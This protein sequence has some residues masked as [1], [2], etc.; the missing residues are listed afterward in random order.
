MSALF[1]LIAFVAFV[2]IFVGL[3]KPSLFNRLSKKPMTRLRALG[4]FGGTF[5]VALILAAA[6]AP[7]V[8]PNENQVA[9]DMG[10]ETET[11]SDDDGSSDTAT[12][13]S[14]ATSAS[15]SEATTNN[16]GQT[17]EEDE[18]AEP[19][20]EP[21]QKTAASSFGNGTFVV[22]TDIQP[23]TYRTR[24]SSYG[25][26]YARLSGF[27]GSFSEIIANANTNAPAVIT[28]S[29]SDKGFESTR[30]G[31]WTQDLSA[32]T[33][34]QTS[35]GDGMYIVGTDIEPGTYK[36]SGSDGCYYARLSGFSGSSG[37][38]L[39]NNNTDTPAIVTIASSDKGFE[40]TRCGTWT[41][42]E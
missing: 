39:A 29:A 7:P 1:G 31:T 4:I 17:N 9:T 26:Y 19:E 2:C 32:I 16:S 22:G 37:S 42:V 36:S 38:I 35:F 34:S 40:A 11:V 25:C 13:A 18:P 23:G 21:E 3:A 20:P 14:T 24:T 27:S 30:C 28:I 41:K 15:A 6:S 33:S 5:F 10:V 8:A 12:P